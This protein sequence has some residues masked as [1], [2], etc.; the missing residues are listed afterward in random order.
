MPQG[1]QVW[2]ATGALLVDTSIKIGRIYGQISK[3]GSGA[4]GSQVIPEWSKG[5]PF[6]LLIQ[7]PTTGT[8]EQ[9]S[10]TRTGTTLNWSSYTT[11]WNLYYGTF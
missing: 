2:D 10:I 9:V 6:W 8:Y 11:G 3:V 5:T 1:L 7:V 4:A